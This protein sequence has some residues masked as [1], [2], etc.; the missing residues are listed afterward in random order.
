M[1]ANATEEYV[2][3]IQELEQQLAEAQQII[4]AVKAGEVDAFAYTREGKMDVLTVQSGDYAYRV[5]VENINAGALNLSEEGLIVYTNA[6]FYDLLHLSYNDIIGSPIQ[7]FIHP[8]SRKS[9]NEIFKKGLAGE[10][11]GEI[12]LQAKESI[13]PVHVALTS[14]YP[15]LQT[16]SM[17]VTDLTEKKQTEEK[18]NKLFSASPLSLT[19]SEITSGKIIDANDTFLETI[20][21]TREECIGHTSIE[22]NIIEEESRQFVLQDLLKNGFVKN[23]EI[24]I[25]NKSGRKIPVLNSIE[26]ITIGDKK[27]F[28][29]AII[30]ISERKKAEMEV[31]QANIELKKMNEELASFAYVSSHDLKEPLRLIQ[32]FISLIILNEKERF[33]QEGLHNF[34][35]I[36]FSVKR[37]QQLIED[38][39]TYSRMNKTEREFQPTDL[40]DIVNR[41]REN[42]NEQIEEARA[43]IEVSDLPVVNVMPH[44]FQQLFT[45]LLS[46][47]IKYKKKDQ[48][49]VVSI[50][51]EKVPAP[52]HQAEYPMSADFYWK[53]SFQDNGIG[54]EK[55]F[56]KKIFEVFQRLHGKDEYSGTGIGLAICKK[57]VENHNGFIIADS[58]L[59][60][61]STFTIY[62]PE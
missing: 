38:L 26:T 58:E 42:L 45:N 20:G 53:I 57:I 24:E 50:K 55:H 22:L 9:F 2:T 8:D 5:L 32:S 27:Y 60:K 56:S 15:H 28:I 7:D 61:G 1:K 47:S 35:R 16:V 10:S 39:L 40:R 33:Y 30:D 34:S 43:V 29:S 54:F 12:N 37:M 3:R 6:Y 48:P 59:E 18:F 46:N 25:R 17:V 4:E 31:Q 23:R 49:L 62:I 36:T 44:Q 13:I 52:D 21:F 51:A 11:K 19:L 14:L 41:V